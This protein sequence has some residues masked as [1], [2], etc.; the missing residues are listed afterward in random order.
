M[1]VYI[2]CIKHALSVKKRRI[3]M[4]NDHKRDTNT[5]DAYDFKR[6][7]NAPKY[8]NICLHPRPSDIHLRCMFL[9]FVWVLF[10]YELTE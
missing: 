7:M 1:N 10:P 3:S 4:E 9:A 5:G 6:Q 2:I 8:W